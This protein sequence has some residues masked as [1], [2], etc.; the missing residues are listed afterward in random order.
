MTAR[1]TLRDWPETSLVDG[2]RVDGRDAQYAALLEWRNGHPTEHDAVLEVLTRDRKVVGVR[3][4]RSSGD[5]ELDLRAMAL[6]E[7]AVDPGGGDGQ[8]MIQVTVYGSDRSTPDESDW[9]D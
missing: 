1:G 8:A 2:P 6:Y 3:V 7:G 9:L 4:V 5:P